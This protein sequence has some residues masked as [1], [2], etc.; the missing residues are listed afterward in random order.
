LGGHS[1]LAVRLVS[2]IRSELNRELPLA[3]LF[4]HPT[5]KA[6]A[7]VL[8]DA[9]PQ[10][11]PAIEPLP[12]EVTPPLSLAQQ[13]LWFLTQLDPAASAAYVI[14]G[15]VQI[16]GA[17]NK[18][19]LTQALDRIMTRHAPLRTRFEQV[20]G[21]AVQIIEPAGLRPFPLEEIVVA[22]GDDLPAFA[23]AFDLST[24][25]L[26]QGRLVCVDAQTHTLRVALHHLIADGWSISLFIRELSTLYAAFN[27]G[28]PDPLPALRIRYGDYAAWQQRHLQGEELQRQQQYWVAHLNGAPDCLTLPAD[29]ARP[30]TQR[31]AGATLAFTLDRELTDA[32]NALSRRHGTTLFMTLLGAWAALLSRLSG[33]DEVVIGAPVAGRTR[34]ELEGLIGMFVNTQPLRIDLSGQVDTATLLARVRATVIAAQAHQDIAFEQIVEAVAPTRSLAHSPL[35][36]VMFS[37]Q[38]TP[39]ATLDMADLALTPL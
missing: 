10:T 11:L 4:E 24:G 31:Y 6:L 15:G 20:Q 39:S 7:T 18:A 12:D 9:E 19:A 2:H 28:Q 22:P 35:F 34:T 30:P 33:Q 27:A 13:R 23:P 38:N 29:H 14:Q 16:Q 36:Q 5:L 8:Q 37:V 26:V 25:P 1:L 21:E 32:L 3:Q 17:L